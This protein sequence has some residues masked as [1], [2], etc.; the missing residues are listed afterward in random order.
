MQLQLKETEEMKTQH[1]REL[2]MKNEVIEGL[3]RDVLQKSNDLAKTK[4]ELESALSRTIE[5][6][7]GRLKAM[8]VECEAKLSAVQVKSKARQVSTKEGK[9]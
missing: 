3:R 6:Y 7:E 8:Q 1:D 5:E 9:E 2:R 4:L